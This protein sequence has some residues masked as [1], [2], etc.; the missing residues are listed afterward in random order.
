MN[1]SL[2]NNIVA[3]FSNFV[4]IKWNSIECNFFEAF[5]D[6]NKSLNTFAINYENS[7][8]IDPLE[9]LCNILKL[10]SLWTHKWKRDITNLLLMLKCVS[11]NEMSVGIINVDVFSEARREDEWILSDM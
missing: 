11:N 4:I 8:L 6:I 7:I 10:L 5:S 9:S 1:I 3:R 2:I